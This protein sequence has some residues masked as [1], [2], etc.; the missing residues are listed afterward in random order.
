MLIEYLQTKWFFRLGRSRSRRGDWSAAQECYERIIQLNPNHVSALANVGNCLHQQGRYAEAIT[1]FD[2]ALQLRND[3]AD[4]HARLGLIYETLQRFQEA[5]ESLTR[6]FRMKPD[7]R[8]DP[9]FLLAYARSLGQM[10]KY[11]EALGAYK[12]ASAGDPKSAEAMAGV[13]WALWLTGNSRDAEIPL[14]QAIKLHRD[15]PAAYDT[16]GRVLREQHRDEE[17]I[18]IW[19]R[20]IELKPT[21][22]EARANLGWALGGVGRYEDA[23]HAM[24]EVLRIDPDFPVHYSIGL[25]HLYLGEYRQA[26]ESEQTELRRGPDADAYNVIAAS[27]LNLGEF[28]EAICAG[29]RAIALDSHSN[30]AWHNMG[31]AYMGIGRC[32]EAIPCFEKALE[33]VPGSAESHFQLGLALLKRGNRTAALKECAVLGGI[34]AGKADELKGA[35]SAE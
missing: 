23:L 11:E 16:L 25:Y 9:I 26:I 10:K 18:P 22:C 4:V 1:F 15:F 33:I 32:G 34:D 27:C 13:G 20:L 21:D 28:Q 24:E 14:V 30:V 6:A 2:R 5:M 35:I 17:S 12:E 7:L 31:E 8:K 3:Y 29:Q 19:E